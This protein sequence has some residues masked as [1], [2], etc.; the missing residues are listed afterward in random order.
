MLW[1]RASG[2]NYTVVDRSLRLLEQIL[3]DEWA[4][5]PA[6]CVH[7]P[8]TLVELSQVDGS[9]PEL[10][11]QRRHRSVRVIV[12]AR[13]K[14]D[15]AATLDMVTLGHARATISRAKAPL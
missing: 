12:I 3:T 9:D 7:Q 13:R 10:F 6:A 11:G 1:N 2:A 4:P 8:A 5:S 15:S 14:D